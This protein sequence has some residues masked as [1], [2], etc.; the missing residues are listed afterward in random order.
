MCEGVEARDV[1]EGPVVHCHLNKIPRDLQIW[2]ADHWRR[3]VLG[4]ERKPS[5]IL[6]MWWRAK[7]GTIG[8][9]MRESNVTAAGKMNGSHE[10][11]EMETWEILIMNGLRRDRIELENISRDTDTMSRLSMVDVLGRERSDAG[12]GGPRTAQSP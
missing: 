11:P 8:S 7:R 4:V 6:T 12:H 5:L 2:K 1:V 3:L 9:R 10:S